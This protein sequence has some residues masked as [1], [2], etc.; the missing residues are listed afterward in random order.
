[1]V[2]R[3]K[4]DLL[5]STTVLLIISIC[6]RKPK[7]KKN[8][9]TPNFL[10]L[11]SFKFCKVFD[12]LEKSKPIQAYYLLSKLKLPNSTFNL[13][14]YFIK[15]STG[16]KK[17]L[18]KSTSVRKA[19]KTKLFSWIFFHFRVGKLQHQTGNKFICDISQ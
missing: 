8:W 2:Q 13:W 11:L 3:N 14:A 12:F 1:M 15:L 19:L 5:P 18:C 17:K 9:A 4:Y 16:K 7:W 6:D 10:K